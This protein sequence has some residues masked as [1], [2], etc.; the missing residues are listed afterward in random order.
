MDMYA[1]ASFLRGH[2][3]NLIQLRKMT[4]ASRHQ[5]RSASLKVAKESTPSVATLVAR[6]ISPSSSG[7]SCASGSES[8]SAG[9]SPVVGAAAVPQT[10]E[11]LLPKLTGLSI[12]SHGF[13]PIPEVTAAK[14]VPQ[15]QA[16]PSFQLAPRKVSEDRGKLDLLAFALEQDELA[17]SVSTFTSC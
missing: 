14:P 8:S 11:I 1:H 10:T 12:P 3:E 16:Q 5:Q 13:A 7:G 6:P 17:R 2:P 4:T 9:S 15:Q